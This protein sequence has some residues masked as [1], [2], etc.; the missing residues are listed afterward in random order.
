MVFLLLHLGHIRVKIFTVIMITAV[1]D[2]RNVFDKFRSV[3]EPE[4]KLILLGARSFHH[5]ARM[6]DKIRAVGHDV[7]A[8]RLRGFKLMRVRNHHKVDIIRVFAQCFERTVFHRTVLQFNA[9][10]VKCIR[11]KIF[12]LRPV[13]VHFLA[14]ESWAIL[15]IDAQ[16]LHIVCRSAVINFGCIA[17]FA[18]K[19]NHHAVGLGRQQI[20]TIFKSSI[21]CRLICRQRPHPR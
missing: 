7:I 4:I 15:R 6:Q 8:D 2:H 5:I 21:G 16:L 19:S 17:G 14:F 3:L 18:F 11:G 10:L 12:Q 1:I 13:N 9:V 20:R